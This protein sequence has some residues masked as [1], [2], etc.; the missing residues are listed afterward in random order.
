MVWAFRL[1]MPKRKLNFLPQGTY[2]VF[3]RTFNWTSPWYSGEGPGQIQAPSQRLTCTGSTL[4]AEGSGWFWQN[5][6][7]VN[8][9]SRKVKVGLR[10]L[11]GF[12][13]RA[14][15]IYFTMGTTPPPVEPD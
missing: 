7:S 1:K 6:G 4:G 5:A 11:T 12:N 15:A 13:G 2:N 10:D 14:D 9:A 8:I 3:V